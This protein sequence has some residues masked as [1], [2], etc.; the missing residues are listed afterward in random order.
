MPS[1]RDTEHSPDGTERCRACLVATATVFELAPI[2]SSHAPTSCVC[3]GRDGS[4]QVALPLVVQSDRP[5]FGRRP[6]Q[7]KRFPGVRSIE[8]SAAETGTRG[9]H[10]M[11]RLA[12]ADGGDEFWDGSRS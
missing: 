11:S 10:P 6:E 3:T 8:P 2:G 4:G 12:R 5:S 9:A 7:D 1:L